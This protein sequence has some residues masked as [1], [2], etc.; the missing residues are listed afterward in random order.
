MG[1]GFLRLAEK[2]LRVSER[3][4]HAGLGIL[5]ILFWKKN[6]TIV[7]CIRSQNL[8]DILLTFKIKAVI[9]ESVIVY[10]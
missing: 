5:W 4:M 3:I 6:K 7:F 8:V 2:R 10:S 9:C 1:G